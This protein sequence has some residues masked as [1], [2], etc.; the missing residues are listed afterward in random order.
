MIR[1]GTGEPAD[2]FFEDLTPGLVFDLGVTAVDEIE[3]ITFAERFD[4]QWYHVDGDLAARSPYRGL[5]ASG[6]FT[7]SLFMRAYVEH[8][9]Q[10]AAADASP[11]IEELRWLAP[12]RGGDRLGTRLEV[13]GRRPSDARPGLGTVTLEGT[14]SRLDAAGYPEEDV[15][16]L[17]FRGWFVRRPAR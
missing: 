4:P 16:R 5:I 17:R 6:W 12:V 9:L 2:V 15:L 1:S 13:L 3:M 11:G 10:R 8:L 14:M 7:A